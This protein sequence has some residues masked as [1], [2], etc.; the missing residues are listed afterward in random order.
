[1]LRRFFIFS[2]LNN[3]EKELLTNML[4]EDAG[5]VRSELTAGIRFSWLQVGRAFTDWRIY[6]YVA[7]GLCDLAVTK[8]LN[9]HLPLLVQN[10]GQ[11]ERFSHF[12]T[13]PVYAIACIFCLLV[14]YSSSHLQ[15]ISF[16]LVFC[17]LVAVLGFILLIVLFD[18]GATVLFVSICVVCCGAFA[19]C[20]LILSLATKNVGGHTKR[21]IAVG[22]VISMSQALGM[23]APQV[24]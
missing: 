16:H 2:G 20:P 19:V 1:M 7:I 5:P 13:A 3:C 8:I 12:I 21:T 4:R 11:T 9:V 6:S 24:R 10:M 14:S 15:E 17:Q 23:I 18:H 22:L